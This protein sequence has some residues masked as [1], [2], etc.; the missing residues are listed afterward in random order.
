MVTPSVDALADEFKGVVEDREVAGIATI[1]LAG[2]AGGVV[3]TQLAG[4]I[5]PVLGFSES[6]TDLQGLLVTGTL[7]M[8]AGVAL[9]LA[10]VQV[11]GTAGAILGIA[12]LGGLILGGGDWINGVLATDVGVPAASSRPRA[13]SVARSTTARSS[14]RARSMHD[15]DEVQFRATDGGIEDEQVQFR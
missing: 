6:P 7:K 15:E 9:V 2:A 8:L 3:A 12:G 13:R 5:A 14:T 11:G 10:G 4:R 1:G